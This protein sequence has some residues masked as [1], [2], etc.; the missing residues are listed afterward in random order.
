MTNEVRKVTANLSLSE[1]CHYL[2]S[3]WQSEIDIPKQATETEI[4]NIINLDAPNRI[5]TYYQ[6]NDKNYF[7]DKLQITVQVSNAYTHQLITYG[8]VNV[9]FKEENKDAINITPQSVEVSEDGLVEIIHQPHNN[10]YYYAEYIS[11]EDNEYYL[12]SKSDNVD[13]IF[14]T[15]PV[16]ME[17]DIDKPFVRP[18]E[19]V[20]LSS[21]LQD[22]YGNNINYGNVTFYTELT[23]DIDNPSDGYE[24]VIGD[25]VV[26]NDGYA[27]IEYSPIQRY[28]DHIPDIEYIY[29]HYNYE[30]NLYGK[31]FKYYTPQRC[32][33]PLSILNPNRIHINVGVNKNSTFQNIYDKYNK[34]D[35][36]LHIQYDEPLFLQ[37]TITDEDNETI[38]NF[39]SNDKVTFILN[40][41]SSKPTSN[42]FNPEDITK[43]YI[44]NDISQ[45]MIG[46][47]NN[48]I[49]KHIMDTPLEPG[50]YTLYARFDGNNK[51]LESESVT[52]Y[53]YVEPIEAQ[54]DIT[55][56]STL[57]ESTISSL[58]KENV[59]GYITRS[60]LSSITD[61]KWATLL[62]TQS[63]FLYLN[64][65]RYQCRLS[66]DKSQKQYKI[67]LLQNI[68]FTQPNN[69]YA[70]IL[71]PGKQNDNIFIPTTN[72]NTILVRV[73]LSL[74]PYIKSLSIEKDKYP[75]KIKGIVG[76]EN[77]F[78]ETPTITVTIDNNGQKISQNY[79]YNGDDITFSFT[80]I[81]ASINQHVI[82]ATVNGYKTAEQNFIIQ[83]AN[84]T[85]YLDMQYKTAKCD[86]KNKTSLITGPNKSISIIVESD[87]QDFTNYNTTNINSID[88]G[89]CKD[90]ELLHPTP[91][92]TK[93]NNNT[94]LK[95]SYQ[96]N[97]PLPTD[98]K[99][100]IV[101]NGDSNYN[102]P[103]I[104]YLSFKTYTITPL[105]TYIRNDDDKTLNISIT[106]KE[107]NHINQYILIGVE[108][109]DMRDESHFSNIITDTNGQAIL[110]CNI[111]A[112]ESDMQWQ[113]IQKII[114]TTNPFNKDNINQINQAS[115]KINKFK[116][117][118]PNLQCGSSKTA[119]NIHISGIINQLTNNNNKCF[120][121]TYSDI[122]S[123]Q[124]FQM[125]SNNVADTPSSGKDIDP[126]E[127]GVD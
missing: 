98:W 126:S 83:R 77:V 13:V 92:V 22:V 50:Y 61:S 5:N 36:F 67:N 14:E 25:P 95:V 39:A 27:E 66:Y 24:Y 111:D 2:S 113:N 102:G 21:T 9:Y 53:I 10:G 72:S 100:G 82:Y 12:A 23:N 87:G 49:F 29:A 97:L 112:F 115:N 20:I 64:E 108:I 104:E 15:I 57:F 31:N 86:S 32:K 7:N 42:Q 78:D 90:T 1:N 84:L 91:T 37:A 18:E 109:Q 79:I 3:Q 44:F 120:F 107:K 96:Q 80:N 17:F 34:N 127:L 105:I 52:L 74:K 110:D 101:F 47:Y 65:I 117:L 58:S 16:I 38:T 40:G 69:Y 93:I 56:N 60:S 106:D 70:K 71:I 118:Y 103:D 119:N 124:D 45:E 55:L 11:D 59:L 94:Q 54:I 68:N 62:N 8:R 28:E 125:E 81:N 6:N 43:S 76:V 35:G 46:N 89:T 85:T 4:I 121:T 30:N 73:R 122:I 48:G 51:L 26:V 19:S 88:I 114:F 41:T 75:G 63:C 123:I 116:E 33:A 99:T